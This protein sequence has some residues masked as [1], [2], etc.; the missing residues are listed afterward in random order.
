LAVLFLAGSVALGSSR[1]SAHVPHDDISYVVTSPTYQT[2][3]TV[4]T[5]SYGRLMRSG[6]GGA[7]WSRIVR[8][9]D[10]QPSRLVIAPSDKQIVYM[11]LLGGKVYKS[12][13]QGRSWAPTGTPAALTNVT[14]LAVS[15]TSSGVAFAA[16]DTAGLFRTT[17]GG[18]SWTKVGSFGAVT[19]VVFAANS[20]RVV[21]GDSGG[22]VATSD[23]NGSTWV[24]SSGITGGEAIT[25][26]ASA[27]YP[28]SSASVF[29][30]TRN[31]HMFRSTNRGTSFSAVGSG[32]PAE[33]VM[34]IGIS[35]RYATDSTLWVST[36]RKGVYQSRNRGASFT[37]KSTG[38][39][40]DSQA[41]TL[42]RPNFG[43]LS[44][45]VGPN[46]QQ[47]LFVS[48]FTGLFRSDDLG[49]HWQQIQTLTEQVVGLAVSPDYAHD[50]TVVATTYVK[51]AYVSNN[52][53]TTWKDSHVGLGT[54]HGNGFAPVYRLTNVRFSPNYRNDG[55]IFSA[56]GTDFLK[57]SDRGASWTAIP[58]AAVPPGTNRETLVIAVSPA[59]VTD[60][61]VYLGSE[62]GEIYRSQ[63]GGAA[64]TWSLLS[65]VGG[66]VRSLVFSPGFPTDPVL[67]VSTEHGIVKSVDA[68][69]H[70]APTGPSGTA[71][72]AIS[73][74]YGLDGTVFAGTV[75]GFFVTRD[76]GQ[77]W[78]ELTAAPLATSTRV[79]A[80]G[81]SPDY[82]ADQTVLVSVKGRGLF[83]STD[84]GSTFIEVGTSLIADN[85]AIADFTHAT[86][87]PIQFSP[88]FSLDHTVFAMAANNIVKSTDSGDTWQKLTLPPAARF[89]APPVIAP[90]PTAAPVTEGNAGQTRVMHVAFDLSHP[91]A[92]QVTVQWHTL[93][94]PGAAYAQSAAGDFVAATG[95]MV[96]PK[97][98]TRQYAD[99]VV[100]G[101]NL[102]EA[103]ETVFVA[104]ANATNATIG[105]FGGLGGG[106][107]HDDDFPVI[108]PGSASISEG[109]AGA[110]VL[111]IPVSL[112]AASGRTV[113]VAWTTL[114]YQATSGQDFA[115]DS[116]TVTFL[117]GEAAKTVD[118]TVFGDITVE[119]DEAFLVATSNPTNATLGGVYGLGAG[120]ILNDD[121]PT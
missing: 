103:D 40:T 118:I 31:G 109:D 60:R 66:I 117:P 65:S 46:G 21:V 111:S 113:T 76:R 112:S 6:D 54:V 77:T 59:Y 51:G 88:V 101:D 68:G 13:D 37:A 25:A 86:S 64:G 72:L 16:G 50:A 32:V 108:T 7:S 80:I 69:F 62:Q 49:G 90:A 41:E 89:L 116:G 23:N 19:A 104:L 8:G 85:I 114:D 11:S 81:V 83:R 12:V 29:V 87:A 39:T 44:V 120:W 43:R 9:F 93:D 84:G 97:G 110:S 53:G 56:G 1:A 121:E 27:P 48:A 38:L 105:G 2:D 34:S 4:F 52:G 22:T 33:Q 14:D 26:I 58:I 70:W 98:A 47:V 73:P 100:K 61:T 57:S 119:P 107:I 20:I 55:T 24:T 71:E 115:P 18:A 45:A 10:Q 17:N 67:Y 96:F 95:T 42:V 63:A 75:H 28:T 3:K 15:P 74:N 82:A 92:L 79:E 91:Y 99:V 36:W 106:I 94:V 30:G 102:E 5:I 35:P 78:A